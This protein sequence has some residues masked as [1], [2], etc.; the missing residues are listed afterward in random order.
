VGDTRNWNV[1]SR[2]NF[3]FL[4]SKKTVLLLDAIGVAGASRWGG[5]QAWETAQAKD[6][7][8]RRPISSQRQFSRGVRSIRLAFNH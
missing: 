5:L 4:L 8:V 7:F 2:R 1:P 3:G 6:I